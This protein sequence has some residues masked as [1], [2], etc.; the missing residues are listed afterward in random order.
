MNRPAIRPQFSRPGEQ[1]RKQNMADIAAAWRRVERALRRGP[2]TG[3]QADAPAKVQWTGGT[4]VPR[5]DLHIEC[6]DI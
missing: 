2:K 6:E 5:I 3:L 1:T 4:K